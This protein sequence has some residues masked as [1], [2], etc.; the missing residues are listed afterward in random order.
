M[1]GAWRAGGGGGFEGVAE[2]ETCFFFFFRLGSSGGRSSGSCC[3]RVAI[4][5]SRFVLCCCVNSEQAEVMPWQWTA[6]IT[7]H[8]AL[9]VRPG[10]HSRELP[11][12]VMELGCR[13]NVPG[14]PYL[15]SR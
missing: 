3:F 13:L 11:V 8:A 7:R 4:E 6:R 14:A 9:A 12:F 5:S 1:V 15:V 10:Q 2:R